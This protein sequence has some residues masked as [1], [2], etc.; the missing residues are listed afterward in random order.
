MDEQK[1]HEIFNIEL[2][3]INIKNITA[4][5]LEKIP[6]LD[7]TDR[8]DINSDFTTINEILESY[9][10]SNDLKV[11]YGTILPTLTYPNYR[12]LNLPENV[13]RAINFIMLE[14]NQFI[15][16]S[17]IVSIPW[18]ESRLKAGVKE[19]L[20]EEQ[21][22]ENWKQVVTQSSFDSTMISIGSFFDLVSK[23]EHNLIFKFE[24]LKNLL[25]IINKIDNSIIRILMMIKIGN[26]V[27]KFITSQSNR[28][29][30][31]LE[32]NHMNT[33]NI[34][35]L[36]QEEIDASILLFNYV[37]VTVEDRLKVFTTYEWFKRNYIISPKIVIMARNIGVDVSRM[38]MRE[39]YNF[40]T[41]ALAYNFKATNIVELVLMQ[42]Y[43][44]LPNVSFKDMLIHNNSEFSQ[45]LHGNTLTLFNAE[46]F[47]N[48][49]RLNLQDKKLLVISKEMFV[50]LLRNVFEAASEEKYQQQVIIKLVNIYKPELL[51]DQELI[52]SHYYFYL[53]RMVNSLGDA[54]SYKLKMLELRQHKK[55]ILDNALTLDDQVN[56]KNEYE[57]DILLADFNQLAKIYN[58]ISDDEVQKYFGFMRYNISWQ[59]VFKGLSTIYCS[60]EC[61]GFFENSNMKYYMVDI[62]NT[63]SDARLRSLLL[64]T[65]ENEL[66]QV[67]ELT[68]FIDQKTLDYY[69]T[70]TMYK[71]WSTG[72]S[73][74]D[75][76]IVFIDDSKYYGYNVNSLSGLISEN[77][78]Y[79]FRPDITNT[80][81]TNINMNK[82]SN[83][84]AMAKFNNR[85]INQLI[86]KIKVI[87]SNNVILYDDKFSILVSNAEIKHQLYLYFLFAFWT[88]QFI[89]F[90]RGPGFPFLKS[91]YSKASS[92]NH[93]YIYC[94]DTLVNICYNQFV[95]VRNNIST[96][97]ANSNLNRKFNPLV[98]D[99]GIKL[100]KSLRSDSAAADKYEMLEN[101]KIFN[102]SIL[103]GYLEIIGIGKSCM[104][105]AAGQVYRFY[106]SMIYYL[107]LLDRKK[108]DEITV[109]SE[110]IARENTNKLLNK[111]SNEMVNIM[112]QDLE[113]TMTIKSFNNYDISKHIKDMCYEISRHKHSDNYVT[114]V[115]QLI[116]VIKEKI[117]NREHKLAQIGNEIY[118]IEDRGK[119]N[120]F[121]T[122]TIIE[123]VKTISSNIEQIQNNQENRTN[124]LSKININDENSNYTNKKIEEDNVRLTQLIERLLQYNTIVNKID[125]SLIRHIKHFNNK[126]QEYKSFLNLLNDLIIYDNIETFFL[127]ILLVKKVYHAKLKN[128]AF[129]YDNL[130][131]GIKISE[132]KLDSLKDFIYDYAHKI[133]VVDNEI[134]Q[135][136]FY[137]Q[138]QTDPIFFDFENPINHK[139]INVRRVVD[140]IESFGIKTSANGLTED[141]LDKEL[142]YYI[143]NNLRD[144]ISP[145][146]NYYVKYYLYYTLHTYMQNATSF[147]VLQPKEYKFFTMH[148]TLAQD[149]MKDIRV[150]YVLE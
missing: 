33:I 9:V 31:V 73:P 14:Q 40:I 11:K 116:R 92:N 95:K 150:K 111:Y 110:E 77:N 25:E 130:N 42:L 93:T 17:I 149:E 57:K 52:D 34:D 144:I 4:P 35:N 120:E 140:K 124:Y 24:E 74:N 118:H 62:Y 83:T 129:D 48:I 56:T 100:M 66:V 102:V 125:S 58:A 126:I 26:L 16:Q 54:E 27:D 69:R 122:K 55:V 132:S 80:E 6:L 123:Q 67:D 63:M 91:E 96:L 8:F 113:N 75:K 10:K 29:N 44:S 84:L 46:L 131:L 107:N 41:S 104:G 47:N 115:N 148:T 85:E 119:L 21:F 39:V 23:L 112:Y 1:V 136:N 30:Q 128:I 12:F 103:N 146:Y 53:I 61:M 101:G 65:P 3:D 15:L 59:D 117:N 98:W 28:I 37:S 134:L 142:Q 43:Y 5:Q 51:T 82:M 87:I 97:I 13:T 138:S 38:S 81:F 86:E 18:R 133:N 72:L 88:I 108:N 94:R 36:T 139:K 141:K 90:W 49:P 50:Q 22:S 79:M 60:F 7:A 99:N 127:Q 64:L 143:Q 76:F 109:D 145:T 32:A 135:D 147:D 105:V 106:Y 19:K 137:N 71:F 70:L 20:N 2:H 45:L 68:R 114:L 78:D 121:N 89:S